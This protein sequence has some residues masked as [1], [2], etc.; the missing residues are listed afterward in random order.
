[1]LLEPSPERLCSKSPPP[2]HI[3]STE[4]I[5]AIAVKFDMTSRTIQ[6]T[7]TASG[8]PAQFSPI[9]YFLYSIIDIT[10]I[11][12]IKSTVAIFSTVDVVQR[13]DAV[14]TKVTTSIFILAIFTISHSIILLTVAIV[15]G[16]TT[17]T[18]KSS[19]SFIVFTVERSVQ[20]LIH[21]SRVRYFDPDICISASSMMVTMTIVMSR[22]IKW[23]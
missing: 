18:T 9:V 19:S 22:A 1:M 15:R 16:L 11:I 2:L 17:A 10:V 14:S 23:R 13:L 3:G 8:V 6:Y 12:V 4:H 7:I 20:L 5:M 21:C